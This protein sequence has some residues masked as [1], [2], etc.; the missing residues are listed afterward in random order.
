MEIGF[1]VGIRSRLNR[2]CFEGLHYFAHQSYCVVG[3]THPRYAGVDVLLVLGIFNV[4]RFVTQKFGISYRI[5][6]APVNCRAVRLFKH[7]RLVLIHFVQGRAIIR[8]VLEA[9]H[10]EC[11]INYLPTVPVPFTSLSKHSS[12]AVRQRAQEL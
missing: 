12:I 6:A 3:S 9:A 5:V 10:S 2:L 1:G 11:H 4:G 8:H 7:L